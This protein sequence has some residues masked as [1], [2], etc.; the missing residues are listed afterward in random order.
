MIDTQVT[1]EYDAV[2]ASRLGKSSQFWILFRGE[3]LSFT[4]AH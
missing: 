2:D 1:L 4:Q 3:I